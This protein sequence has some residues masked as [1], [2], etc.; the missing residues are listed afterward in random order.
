DFGARSA[1]KN[2]GF[3]GCFSSMAWWD[4]DERWFVEEHRVQKPLGWQIAFPEPPFGR[5]I[6]HGTESREILER[7]AVRALR[8]AASLGG[9]LMVP[10]G[11]ECGAATPLD[12]THGNGTG[13]RGLRHDLAFDISSEIRLANTEIG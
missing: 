11:F 12:P 6:A 9:G 2:T 10:M 3:D 1:V 13:L 7:R 5:R 8:L 4:F